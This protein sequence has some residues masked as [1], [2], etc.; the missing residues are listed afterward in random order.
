MMLG[1]TELITFL[2]RNQFLSAVQGETLLKEKQRFVSSVQ[3]CA[4]LV[5]R[6]WIT[7]YQQAQILSGHGEKLIIGSYRLQLPIGEGGMGMVFKAVQPKLDR[8]VALKIIR[9]QV[10]AARPEILSRFHRE[11]RAIAQLHHPNLVILFDADES[12]GTHFIAMEYVEGQTFEKMVRANGPMGIRQACE[13]IRQCA[14]GLQHAYEVGL[15]HRDIK[16]SNILVSQ[17]SAAG[18]SGN[19]SMRISRPA[20]VTIRDRERQIQVGTASKAGS[21]WGT[22]KILDM[23]LARLTELPEEEQQLHENTPLTRAG[24][25]LGTPDFIAPEQARDA[26]KVDIRADIYSLGCTFYYML[27]GKPP[28]PGGTDVQ[29]LIRHQ[30]EKPYPVEELRPGIPGEVLN[31]LNRMLEKRPEDRYTTPQQLA[32][33]LTHYLTPAVPGTQYPTPTGASVAETPSLAETPTPHR[34]GTIE[35]SPKSPTPPAKPVPNQAPIP[36]P[37]GNQPMPAS[38]PAPIPSTGLAR[39]RGGEVPAAESTQRSPAAL[40]P[41]LNATL[42]QNVGALNSKPVSSV[43]AHPGPVG[44][45]DISPDGRLV[46]TAGL[47]GKIR[48]WE[49]TPT[50]LKELT[51]YMYRG[52]EFQ[53][54]IFHPMEDY[55]VVA[56]TYQGTARVWA[57]DWRANEFFEWGA[58]RG[59][60]ILVN[61]LTF[62]PDGKKFGAAIGAF[63][64]YWKVSRRD[65]AGSGMILKGHPRTVRSVAFSPDG[66]LLV[67]AG[68][69]RC[70]VGWGFGWLGVSQK[71]KMDGIPDIITTI[72]FTPNGQRFALA[73]MDRIIRILDTSRPKLEKAAM[74]SGH[75]TNLRLAKFLPD[76]R[77]LVVVSDNGQLVAWNS[78]SGMKAHELALSTSIIMTA[79]LS[80]DGKCLALGTIDGRLNLYQLPEICESPITT[81]NTLVASR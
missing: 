69:G 30:T 45:V 1:P 70:V 50:G 73:G 66:K 21:S 65:A 42:V 19:S 79:A 71:I 28:F 53:S 62:S 4:E 11:A 13:Y 39:A 5:Q 10:L 9:P 48:M 52:A 75:N 78:Q 7:A 54:V 63:V 61:S 24:A 81:V 31:I 8:C 56:G 74:L 18:A 43:A 35:P 27:T 44:G 16:P 33:A 51:S 6:N 58:Y 41:E 40:L 68:E 37:V 17:K 12:N 64:V 14:V 60:K 80:T 3:L 26:R 72:S 36:S 15:V 46:I 77:T 47:D 2:T 20:L 22:V 49:N 59:D 34:P 29:K 38:G 55:V 32:D 67:S 25:L 57:W 76:S 23:G